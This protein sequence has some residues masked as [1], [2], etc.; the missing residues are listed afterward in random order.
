MKIY[1]AHS[2]YENLD[3]CQRIQAIIDYVNQL[4]NGL[5][6]Y[7]EINSQAIESYFVDYYLAQVKNGGHRQFFSNSGFNPS[8]NQMVLNGLSNMGA[9]LHEENFSN[10]LNI[11]NS[12]PEDS[13]EEVLYTLYEESIDPSFQS[14]LSSFDAIDTQFYLNESLSDLNHDYI[15][16]FED[17]EIVPDNVFSEK[18][19]ILLDDVPNYENRQQIQRQLEIENEP[20]YSK[21]A[22][23]LCEHYK[24]ELISINALDHG[25]GLVSD[26]EVI[27]NEKM[28]NYY[29]YFTTSKGLHYYIYN[30]GDKTASLFKENKQLVG[31]L[32][33]EE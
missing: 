17:L 29:C 25:Q 10:G 30:D 13:R 12:I 28:G 27:K 6:E 7:E 15:S 32:D 4:V 11:L 2:Q 8:I 16:R 1:I 31:T 33:C 22:T 20:F 21:V 9:Y 19:K 26:N 5:Y 18:I 3:K 23:A 14:V 24:H